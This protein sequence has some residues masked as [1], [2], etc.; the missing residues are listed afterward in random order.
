MMDLAPTL[1]ASL[2]V[3]PPEFMEGCLLTEAFGPLA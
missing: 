3:S 1:L 2:G